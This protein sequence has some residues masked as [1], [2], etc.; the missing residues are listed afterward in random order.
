MS[1]M[2]S[3]RGLKMRKTVTSINWL[4]DFTADLGNL[5]R[6]AYKVMHTLRQLLR[7]V[8]NVLKATML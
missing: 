8:R 1:Y 3:D 4:R 7:F 6:Y 5:R 2:D